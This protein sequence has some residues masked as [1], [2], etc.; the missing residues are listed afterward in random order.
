MKVHVIY[1]SPEVQVENSEEICRDIVM[2]MLDKVFVEDAT[3][4][5]Q[6]DERDWLQQKENMMEMII[7]LQQK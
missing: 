4:S 7:N 5:I 2:E 6:V 1:T 3:E